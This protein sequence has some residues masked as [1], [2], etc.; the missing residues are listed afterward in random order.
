MIRPDF[1]RVIM[2][3]FL[4]AQTTLD[5]SF[6]LLRAIDERFGIIRPMSNCLEDLR[7][8]TNTKHSFVP[9]VRQRI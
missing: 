5:V 1:N 2:L 7:S 9:M 8:P 4:G 6:L 3:A